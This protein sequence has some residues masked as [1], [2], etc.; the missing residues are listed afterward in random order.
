MALRQR[1]VVWREN[2]LFSDTSKG[3]DSSAV[4][5]TLVDSAK[6]NVLE[7]RSYLWFFLDEMRYLDNS[8]STVELEAVMPWSP[9]GA[10]G[11]LYPGDY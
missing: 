5:Y 4:I 8:P 10:V 3:A 9:K 11:L 1:R 2:C 6:A 7:P